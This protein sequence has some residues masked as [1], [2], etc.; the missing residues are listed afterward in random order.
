MKT[1]KD[2]IV[3]ARV[4]SRTQEL[5]GYSLDSQV[6]LLEDYCERKDLRVKKVFQVSETA[7]RSTERK[8][9]AECLQYLQ[10]HRIPCLVI[11]KVDRLTRN[12]YDHN[13][14]D[15][16]IRQN[17]HNEVHSV[18]DSQ[19]LSKNSRSQ[20]TLMWD[21]KVTL[22]KNAANNLSEEV[23][24]GQLEK[25][26]Q[27]WLPKEPPIGYKTVITDG[28]KHLH[29]IDS[30][31]AP[32]V[33]KGFE[34]YASPDHTILS[35]AEKLAKLGLKTLRGKPVT[36]NNID[37]MLDNK[38]YIGINCWNGMELAGKQETII[39]EELWEAVQHKKHGVDPRPKYN[40]HD[41]LLRG[42]VNC[43]GCKRLIIW[44]LQKGRYYGR[45]NAGCKLGSYAREEDVEAFLLETI[46]RTTTKNPEVYSWLRD[47]LRGYIRSQNALANVDRSRLEKL[48]A[49]QQNKLE[50]LY[51]DR[52][53]E[54]ITLESY[55]QKSL[56]ITAS[57]EQLEEEQKELSLNTQYVSEKSVQIVS[58][59]ARALQCY[60]SPNASQALKREILSFYFGT[61]IWDG[62]VLKAEL[63]ELAELVVS[64]GKSVVEAKQKVEPQSDL[65][66][67]GSLEPSSTVW[68]G[69]VESNHDL[70]FWRPLY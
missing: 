70:G 62:R 46:S 25:L 1:K 47:E 17:E 28:K 20:D 29:E 48:I 34:L 37:L 33:I 10:K 68:Q 13:L 8:K 24:K 2:A 57:I 35:V 49:T 67:A 18:K 32:L 60:T 14:I 39:S 4:S 11:E 31:K 52:L 43:A 64:L 27:G 6:K 53:A 63:S 5:E 56:A 12:Y 45:C 16:W 65:C 54:V 59:C 44:Q 58:L 41:V 9:F 55:K 36:K 3:F 66:N 69:Y 19:V 61:L 15:T 26:K 50:V 30:E 51:E 22:A 21:L 23:K 42:L 40:K 7:T 38:F